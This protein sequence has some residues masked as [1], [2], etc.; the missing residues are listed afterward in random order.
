ML[1]HHGALGLAS[2]PEEPHSSLP[3]PTVGRLLPNAVTLLSLCCGMS[4]IELAITGRYR[5]AAIAIIIAGI[6][7]GLDGRAAR[8]FNATSTFGAELDSLVDLVSFGV[9][10]ALLLYHWSLFALAGFGWAFAVFYAACCGLRLARFNTGLHDGSGDD[11]RGS[12]TGVP[13]PAGAGLVLIP[14]F[15]AFASGHASVASPT[16]NAA[17]V[18]GVALLMVS[19][20]PTWS[21]KRF[22]ISYDRPVPLLAASFIVAVLLVAPWWT[23]VAGGALYAASIPASFI[24]HRRSLALAR[25]S[26]ERGPPGS[27][28]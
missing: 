15:A 5:A 24:A 9:A 8:L 28:A 18:V 13:A 14:M 6:L 21:M 10:P 17:T 23:L 12:F 2:T 1:K 20:L 7:D 3:A 19:R 27:S 22:R 25:Q 16:I 11:K 26:G 4:A